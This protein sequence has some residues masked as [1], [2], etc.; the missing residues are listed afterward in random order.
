M[1][2]TVNALFPDHADL[3]DHI[4][5][6]PRNSQQRGANGEAAEVARG[7]KCGSRLEFL[8]VAFTVDTHSDFA[9][10]GHDL[11]LVL[12]HHLLHLPAITQPDK[13]RMPQVTVRRPIDELKLAHEC[14]L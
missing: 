11:I 10:P 9:E 5:W 4:L 6:E 2:N 13:T 1:T 12:T 7:M 14:G 8:C 3:V